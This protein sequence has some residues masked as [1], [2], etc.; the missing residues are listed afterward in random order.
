VN[1]GDPLHLCDRMSRQLVHDA[2]AMGLDGAPNAHPTPR[3]LLDYV[4]PGGSSN[5]FTIGINTCAVNRFPYTMAPL[6]FAPMLLIAEQVLGVR[7]LHDV[8]A[9]F[10]A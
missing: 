1:R 8:Y 9:A 4:W 5:T 6:I 7:K 2:L 3:S 10:G